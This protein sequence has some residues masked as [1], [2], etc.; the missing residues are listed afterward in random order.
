[1][2]LMD[3]LPLYSFLDPHDFKVGHRYRTTLPGREHDATV[4]SVELTEDGQIVV[5]TFDGHRTTYFADKIACIS[6]DVAEA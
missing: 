2:E 5:T 6:I 3:Q 1:M 4:S